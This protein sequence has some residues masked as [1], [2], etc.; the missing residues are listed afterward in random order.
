MKK[1]IPYL[2]IIA[3]VFGGIYYLS[4]SKKENTAPESSKPMMEDAIDRSYK[5]E[6]TSNVSSIKPG[7]KTTIAFR[8]KN[9]KGEIFKN[10]EVAHE[11]IMHFIVVRK[12]LQDF[13]HLHPDFNESTGEFSVDVTFPN[14]GL[15]RIFPDFTPGEDNPQKL[16]VT[17][18]SDVE[19]GDQTKYKTQLVVADK[20]MKKTYGDY[21]V[22]FTVPDVK[23]QEEFTYN[24]LI[25]KN[26]QPVSDLDKYLGALGHSVIIKEGTLDFIHT[27]AGETVTN[28]AIHHG[29]T[30]DDTEKKRSQNRFHYDISRIWII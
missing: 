1:Y 11:K 7:Q 25:E 19:V 26:G 9:D 28:Q 14:D 4:T 12:D 20:E 17:V 2:L 8:I 5:L 15:H 30:V 21:Q 3:V 10:F 29:G 16:P 22:T 23:A 24:L 27:H 6:V 18:S 13:Q